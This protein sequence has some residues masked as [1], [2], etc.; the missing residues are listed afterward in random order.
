MYLIRTIGLFAVLLGTANA[1]DAPAVKPTPPED[2]ASDSE[3]AEDSE[4]TPAT[5]PEPEEA[6]AEE[7]APEAA[8]EETS[9]D[10]PEVSPDSP[11][12]RVEV[13]LS[14]GVVLLGSVSQ[15]DLIN[16]EP[17]QPLM[18]TP[19]GGEAAE[20]AGNRIQ[21]LRTV[22]DRRQ[23]PPGARPGPPG[24]RPPQVAGPSQPATSPVTE[25]TGY[26][27]PLGYKY[28][29]PAA[30]RYLYAPSSIGL[31]KG[32]GYVSQK[33]VFTSAAYAVTDNW[34]VLYGAFTFFPPALSVFGTKVTREIKENL[35][36]SAGG[37]AFIFGLSQNI[38]VAIAFGALTLGDDDR[39]ITVATGYSNGD[40]FR[41][42]TIPLMVGGQYRFK[43]N[44]ALVTENWGFMNMD[45][46]GSGAG[47]QSVSAYA[48]SLALRIVGRRDRGNGYPRGLRSLSGH[49][50]TTWDI[51]LIAMG[52]R[53]Q[54]TI[55]DDVN[56]EEIESN[57]YE[58]RGF[59][60][61]P[62]I[63]WTWHFG[64]ETKE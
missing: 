4:P 60:P 28:P 59:G 12:M 46:Y 16:W 9:D 55:Y 36:F 27:S 13:T 25:D 19:R 1:Q 63:D 52:I 2:T 64:P 40:F 18:F 39:N 48:S 20:L 30:S 8:A 31:Q 10:A 26:R 41:A 49:P 35:H 23:G 11:A 37:E 53:T 47:L 32:Q 57:L 44:F 14:S 5:Q 42:P 34:T 21:S 62:W 17:G 43:E 51:G 58:W 3:S 33:F 61:L 29:N 24:D 50:R 45:D 56:G 6:P 22:G 54:N 38:P 7:A 15:S